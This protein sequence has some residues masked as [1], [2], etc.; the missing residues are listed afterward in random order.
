MVGIY[1]I[2]NLYTHDCYIGKSKHVE[3]R[4]KEHFCKGY[5]AI[6]SQRFQNAID[7]YGTESFVFELLEECSIPDLH[8]REAYWIGKLNPRYNTIFSGHKLSAVTRAKISR[9]LTGKRQSVETIE[10]RKASIKEYH[11]THPQTNEGHRK[12]VAI[13]AD[14]VLEFESVKA[15]TEYLGVSDGVVSKALK[16][17]GK[18]RGK[19][20]WYVV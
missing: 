8:E 4:W 13:E 14:G 17:G 18:V 6:H 10:K 16:R 19:K 1:K 11:K 2:T 20:V 12:R 7:E 15:L 3:K 9:S 5:G